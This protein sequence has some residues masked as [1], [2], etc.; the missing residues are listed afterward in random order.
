MESKSSVDLEVFQSEV[1][2]RVRNAE[3]WAVH[4]KMFEEWL[5]Q[6]DE[7]GIWNA[8]GSYQGSSLD[9]DGGVGISMGSI[10]LTLNLLGE[11][12]SCSDYLG[13]GLVIARANG[14]VVNPDKAVD[15]VQWMPWCKAKIRRSLRKNI[16]HRLKTSG[17][18]EEIEGGDLVLTGFASRPHSVDEEL[19]PLN[20]E[21]EVDLGGDLPEVEVVAANGVGSEHT[22]EG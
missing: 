10:D 6:S 2:Q 4:G 21:D 20:D 14:G 15:L 18:F 12:K 22:V 19:E 8:L 5:A 17:L 9:T 13:A 11:L 7:I 1:R 16:V 3:A